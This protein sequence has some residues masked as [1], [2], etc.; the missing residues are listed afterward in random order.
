V[1]LKKGWKVGTKLTFQGEGNHTHPKVPSGDLVFVIAEAPHPLFERTVE[2][3]LLYI[4]RVSLKEALCGHT[5]GLET[6]DQK[7]VTVSVPEVVSPNYQKVLPGKGMPDPSTGQMRDL[8][9]RWD[10][11]FPVALGAEDKIKIKEVLG[12]K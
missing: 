9:I 12:A 10:I 11:Q 5:V 6:L 1:P 7:I 2:G 8:V 4:H 3:D